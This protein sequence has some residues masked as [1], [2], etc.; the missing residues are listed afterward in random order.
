MLTVLLSLRPYRPYYHPQAPRF[1][2][3]TNCERGR[4]INRSI[5]VCAPRQ[6]YQAGKVININCVLAV[7]LAMEL[8]VNSHTGGN[9]LYHTKNILQYYIRI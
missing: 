8:G 7:G 3:P 1:S 2:H 9:S 4:M 5:Y 6:I